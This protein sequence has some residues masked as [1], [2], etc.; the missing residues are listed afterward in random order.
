M[1]GA[2][3][4]DLPL[5]DEMVFDGAGGRLAPRETLLEQR[6]RFAPS[7]AAPVDDLDGLGQVEIAVQG[8]Q[9]Q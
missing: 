1:G 3:T 9:G 4:R 5:E 7:R 6:A 2:L 8:G